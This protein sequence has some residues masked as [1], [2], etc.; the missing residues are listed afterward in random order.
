MFELDV[1]VPLNATGTIYPGSR[2]AFGW[3]TV[4]GFLGVMIATLFS[5]P[6]VAPRE[7]SP[8]RAKSCWPETAG[9]RR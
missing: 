2:D 5:R 8:A 9:I 7:P 6:R 1:F 3:L 4:V